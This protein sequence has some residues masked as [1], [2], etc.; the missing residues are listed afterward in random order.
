MKTVHLVYAILYIRE[1]DKPHLVSATSCAGCISNRLGIRANPVRFLKPINSSSNTETP[2][3]SVENH[4]DI[5]FLG[6]R[7]NATSKQSA[8]SSQ[9]QVVTKWAYQFRE[10]WAFPWK[11]WRPISIRKWLPSAAAVNSGRSCVPVQISR[12][13][14]FLPTG[15]VIPM[16]FR[17]DKV[18]NLAI[19]YPKSDRMLR[20][21]LFYFYF[22]A[23]RFG[24]FPSNMDLDF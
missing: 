12:G 20:F 3:R 13:R 17:R 21:P 5:K 19:F 23:G 7:S 18:I 10:K 6:N 14:L 2:H 16:P 4:R 9:Q 1:Y 15:D 24:S 22:L 8:V 11:W